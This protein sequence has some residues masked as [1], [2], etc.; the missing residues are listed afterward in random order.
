MEISSKPPPPAQKK[1]RKFQVCFHQFNSQ[2]GIRR[3][4]ASNL[5]FD[6]GVIG[7]YMEI[8]LQFP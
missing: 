7:P 2:Y 1:P 5:F 6:F 8:K 3:L 4:R